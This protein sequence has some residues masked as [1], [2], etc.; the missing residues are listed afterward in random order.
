MNLE[1]RK[2]VFI[3]LF[4]L[5]G[6]TYSFR[7]FY[8]QVMD[9]QWIDRAREVALKK[10]DI[11]PPRGIF[12][13]RNGKKIVA[14]K[15]YY[16]LMFIENDIEDLDT[17]AFSQLIGLSV[18]SIRHQFAYIKKSLDRK[19]KSKI[20]G[21]D[22]IVNDYRNYLPYPFL[23]ELSADE[24]ARIAIDLPYFKGFYE[25]PI[26][27]RD[28]TYPVGANIFGYL[29]EINGEE[30]NQDRQFYS[31]GDFIG[32]TGLEKYYE[33]TL[34]GQ[35]GTRLILKSAK[36]KVIN[37][38]AEGKL[39]TFAVQCPP[40][41][42]GLDIILQAYGEKLMKNKLGSVVA[43]DPK[44]GE[45]LAMVS[46]PNYDPNLMVGSR[47]IKRNYS[48]LYKDS[49]KPFY[50]RPLAAE[51]PP[52]SIF[53]TVQ[54]L[55]A[56]QEGVIDENFSAP[57]NK[58]LVGCHNHPTAT[59]ISKGI[60][61][62]CN[63][64]FYAVTRKI[65]QQDKDKSVFKDATIGMETWVKYVHSFGLGVTPQTDIYG[66]RKGLIPD[67]EFYNK[68]YG[69]YR[70]AFSTIR[71]N[72]IGQGEIKL[73]PLQMANLA[74]II[75]NEGYY[76]EPHFVKSIGDNGPLDIYKEK[77]HTMIDPSH[78]G[79][80]KEGMRMAVNE[81]G[82]TAARAR[83][84]GITVAGKTGTAQNPH[85]EDHSVFVAFAPFEDPKIAI[86]VFV[87]NAG[88]G[89]TWAAPI[90]SLMIEKYLTG[91]ISDPAKEER[92]FE[93]SFYSTK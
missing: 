54:A 40:L 1:S 76:Y 85:G 89:G 72:S 31:M 88:F 19:T 45:I 57:C 6:V 60:Q 43:I 34:R 53:K 2:I 29:N 86:A 82:G 66:M 92:I 63:P 48:I 26:S 59:S 64:Y 11:K 8:M 65:L 55:I 25:Y 10:L 74:A 44:T 83:I 58:A 27:M 56:L 20:T 38:F 87:E 51:Y 91:K 15:T 39:D 18:D 71:S 23:K 52:G 9:N 46:S 42:L 16:N 62:S 50:P 30:L 73:T 13:D 80:I 35:K 7:L 4:V 33:K 81:P 70:W 78:F 67:V 5:M 3:L 61:Y 36:G 12:F 32:R 22:T 28:Y 41:Y 84:P 47:N 68:W 24:M 49:L 69:E 93:K 37:N 90:A 77:K 75:A 17:I 14:N 79:V 21:Q